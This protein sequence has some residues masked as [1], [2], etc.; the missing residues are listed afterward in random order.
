MRY[1][2]ESR[3]R[4]Y[5]KGYGFLSFSKNVGKNLSNKYGQKLF[6]NAKKFST[7]AL[8][9]AN[10]RAIGKTAIATGNLIGDKIADKIT[11]ISKNQQKS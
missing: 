6:D 1:S 9:T 3:E 10:K 2:I 11:S 4:R 5:V 8:K 7:D